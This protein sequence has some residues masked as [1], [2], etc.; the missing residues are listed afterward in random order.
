[1]VRADIDSECGLG[2]VARSCRRTSVNT[3]VVLVCACLTAPGAQPPSEARQPEPVR[4]PDPARFMWGFCQVCSGDWPLTDDEM[5]EAA[6]VAVIMDG[7]P[8]LAHMAAVLDAIE[9]HR[10]SA[11]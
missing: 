7:G 10:E 1:M 5:K 9:A 6:F 3:L 2:Y 11:P 8:S 4:R